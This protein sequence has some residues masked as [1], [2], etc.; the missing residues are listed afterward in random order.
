MPA[1][2]RHKQADVIR[3]QQIRMRE[4]KYQMRKVNKQEPNVNNLSD[5][6]ARLPTPFYSLDSLLPS[7]WLELPTRR[8]LLQHH[9]PFRDR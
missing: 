2:Q 7:V 6:T 1:C 4:G 8:T 3:R 9:Y 5:V